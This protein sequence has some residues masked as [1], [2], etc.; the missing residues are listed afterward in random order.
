M[1]RIPRN[2]V[3]YLPARVYATLVG[4]LAS[5]LDAIRAVFREAE[6]GNAIGLGLTAYG[7]ETLPFQLAL[8]DHRGR[9]EHYT[10]GM[11]VHPTST[12]SQFVRGNPHALLGQQIALFSNGGVELHF[13][14]I[15]LA[16]S[17][18]RASTRPRNFDMLLP[19]DPLRVVLRQQQHTSHANGRLAALLP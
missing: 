8:T 10:V 7:P 19:L 1:P 9:R 4:A 15:P 16:P 13:A 18:G 11:L 12:L 3:R 6:V 14:H 5:K 17:G 2:Q